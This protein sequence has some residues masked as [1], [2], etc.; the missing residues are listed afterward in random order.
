MAKMK[1]RIAQ[2][3]KSV[4]DGELLDVIEERLP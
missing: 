2:E 4:T 3:K 1:E